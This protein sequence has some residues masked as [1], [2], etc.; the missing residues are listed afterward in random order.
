MTDKIEVSDV[1]KLR[2]ELLSMSVA[3][4]ERRKTE[5]EMALAQKAEAEREAARAAALDEAAIMHLTNPDARRNMV[6]D[7]PASEFGTELAIRVFIESKGKSLY[8]H[9]W[10]RRGI[11]R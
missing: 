8:R 11:A 3:E 10:Q 6:L 5:I 4:L 9:N 2:P 7:R 1:S